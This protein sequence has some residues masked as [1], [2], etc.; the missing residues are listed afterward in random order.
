MI[1]LIKNNELSLQTDNPVIAKND[2]P[3]LRSISVAGNKIKTIVEGLEIQVKQSERQGYATGFEKGRL[4]GHE[5]AQAEVS[6]LMALLARK[7]AD[8]K[9]ELRNSV[10]LL[11]MQV[12]R[13]IA[14][15]LGPEETVAA[16]V[17]TAARQLL[18]GETMT[19]SVHPSAMESVK[20]KMHLLKKETGN[21]AWIKVCSD[22]SLGRFDCLL[23]TGFGTTVA[24]LDQQLN[25][26]E[27]AL[28][29]PVTP[30]N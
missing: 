14:E 16:L 11:S 6:Q 13:K 5:K 29:A 26:L 7:A 1:T 18:S 24:S 4:L 17:E 20:H 8:D 30:S 27:K 10:A 19:I 21:T 25:S 12:V 15:A 2:V 22:N 3:H 9:L 23:K 28:R